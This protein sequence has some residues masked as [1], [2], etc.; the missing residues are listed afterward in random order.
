M[1]TSQES[2]RSIGYRMP[3]E[4]EPHEATW[5]SWPY[6][7]ETWQGNFLDGAEEA[8]TQL[9]AA[10]IPGERV[11]LL[12][13]NEEVEER[14]RSR[15]RP[16]RIAKEQLRWHTIETG[17]CWFRDFGPIFV[18]KKDMPATAL[19]SAVAWTKW[20]YNAYGG[21]WE[22]LLM[23][24]DVP[25]KMPLK[26]LPRFDGGMVLEGGSID[27]N[28]SGSLLTTES[29]LLSPDR[30]P[31]LTKE[32]IEGRLKD[33]LGVMNILWLSSGIAGDD[34]TGHIDDLTRF[35]GPS[36]VVTV[37]ENDPAEEN[38]QP[39]QEN[40]R[41][42]MTM[43]DERGTPLSV[44]ALPMPRPFDVEGRRMAASYANFYI[45]NG[46]VVAPTY[47]QPSDDIALKTLRDLFSDREVMG[48]DCTDL[49][50]GYGAL[51]CVTMQQAAI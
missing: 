10:L 20:G 26:D 19:A 24:N 4:W 7:R 3:A 43:K 31:T 34:T 21:K 30:N 16:L 2:P 6:N 17:D 36:T 48:I 32:E 13:P 41:R 23:G 50:Y 51:H 47:R 39:L 1:R 45:A 35:V 33:F 44:I 11:E 28:G 42:L 5:L 38:Y 15:L 49:I 14:A 18:V 40:M 25:D 37:V 9:I 29:C 27:V 12:V 46:A 8:F 22:D